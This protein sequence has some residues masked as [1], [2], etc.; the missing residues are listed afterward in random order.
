MT[1]GKMLRMVDL[2]NKPRSQDLGQLQKVD[3]RRRNIL[4]QEEKISA[5]VW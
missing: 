5:Q 2:E 3:V 1:N 4:D